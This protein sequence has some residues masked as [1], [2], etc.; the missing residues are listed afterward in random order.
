M[1]PEQKV[2]WGREPRAVDVICVAI[3]SNKLKNGLFY[4]DYD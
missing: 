2:H 3:G 4:F 1:L